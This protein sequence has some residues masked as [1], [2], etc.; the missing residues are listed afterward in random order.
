MEGTRYNPWILTYLEIV[1]VATVF[2]GIYTA[3]RLDPWAMGD[4]LINYH[5][6]FVRRGLTGEV[7][8]TIGH[9]LHFSPPIV[10][11]L[12]QL[13][14]YAAIFYAV[15]RLLVGRFVDTR[16]PFWATLAVISPA[17]LAFPILEQQGGFRKEIIFIG[18]LGILILLTL[19]RPARNALLIV[20]TSLLI[21]VCVLS[22]ESL[23]LFGAYIVAAL[24]IG[25]DDIPRAFKLSVIPTICAAIALVF[26]S[27][28]A[29]NAQMT[30]DICSSL[31]YSS[32]GPLPEP[33]SGAID[34]LRRNLTFAREQLLLYYRHFHYQY[35]YT[36][37]AVVALLPVAMA[38]RALW[39]HVASRRALIVIAAAALFS[40]AASSPLFFYALDWG[41]WIYIHVFCIVLLLFLVQHLHQK[42]ASPEPAVSNGHS[43]LRNAAGVIF[44]V[45][46]AT[47]WE[48]PAVG[49][50]SF[51]AGYVR[52]AT[53]MFKPPPTPKTIP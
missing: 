29:G 23:I 51:P 8:L 6:G 20:Y 25:L 32:T 42:E 4:W 34:Y 14:C 24:A 12:M 35:V 21:V 17:T 7:A 43:R 48:L 30:R 5:A 26:V 1:A 31:G 52:I 28:H 41:R 40:F 36:T 37:L 13:A 15:H 22:H 45:I 44:L 53:A 27:H 38:Y 9:A 47:C 19:R 46:Y 16:L 11:S 49:G 18:G 50:W 39:R 10:V 3:N 2:F 33:C